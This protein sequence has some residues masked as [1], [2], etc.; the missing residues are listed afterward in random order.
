N[1]QHLMI[2][3]AAER[4]GVATAQLLAVGE[5]KETPNVVLALEIWIGDLIDAATEI[6]AV[7]Q[8]KRPSTNDAGEADVLGQHGP[9]ILSVAGAV[10][11]ALHLTLQECGPHSLNRID[12][13]GIKLET[14]A[15]Q[16]A[17]STSMIEFARESLGN[18][19]MRVPAISADEVQVA[20][21]WR[22]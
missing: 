21:H 19:F 14:H 4:A 7:L 9:A 15:L 16:G 11:L 20:A 3:K 18:C 1:F 10:F 5:L 22:G 12:H 6:A 13:D 2:S 17:D 8:V